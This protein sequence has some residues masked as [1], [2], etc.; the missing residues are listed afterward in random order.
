MVHTLNPFQSLGWT[1]KS[2]GILAIHN[3]TLSGENGTTRIQVEES[4]EGMLARI[5]SGASRKNLEQ[6][7]KNWLDVL[8]TA[9]ETKNV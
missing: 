2:L 3:W 1:G 5:F 6:G 7:M 9:C 4:M 8:K